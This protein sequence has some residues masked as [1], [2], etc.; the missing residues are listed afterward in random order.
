MER[1]LFQLSIIPIFHHSIKLLYMNF[2]AH[3]YLSN[4]QHNIIIGNFL[5]DFL[6]GRKAVEK[7]PKAIQQGIVIH[8]KIDKFTDKHPIVKKGV[9]R[10]KPTQGGYAS[11][12]IDVLYDYFLVKNWSSFSPTALPAFTA[13]IYSHLEKEILLFPKSLQKRLPLMITNDWL[14]RYGDIDGLKFTFSKMSD[15]TSF[16][17]NFHLATDD[18]LRFEEEFN[19]EFLTFFPELVEYVDIEIKK[20]D[21]AI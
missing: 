20:L 18:L 7:L 15:R 13:D 9:K 14:I 4:N 11:V 12:I 2:L 6:R 5:A 8:R 3:A 21:L 1:W 16:E 10:L 17:D 19:E